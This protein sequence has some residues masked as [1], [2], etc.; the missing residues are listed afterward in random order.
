MRRSI[1][2]AERLR[3]EFAHAW[4][5]ATQTARLAIGLPDYDAYCAH[6]RE[7]HPG[8]T[9]MSRKRFA[10]ARMEARYGRDASRCC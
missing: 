1:R 7:R 4:R 5:V 8:E 10:V 9:P 3:G 2:F 6:V